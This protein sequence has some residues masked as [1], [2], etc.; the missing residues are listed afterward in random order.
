MEAVSC[1]EIV[2]KIER[3]A[4]NIVSSQFPRS[5]MKNTSMHAESR[6]KENQHKTKKTG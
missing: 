1:Q 4:K 3:T 5:F 6:Q 2:A